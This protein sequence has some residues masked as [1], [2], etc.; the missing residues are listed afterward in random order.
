[1]KKRLLVPSTTVRKVARASASRMSSLDVIKC[2]AAFGVVAIHVGPDVLSFIVRASV[3]MFFLI[4]GYYYPKLVESG[5]FWPHVRKLVAMVLLSSLFYGIFFFAAKWHGGDLDEWLHETFR[6]RH[7][8]YCLVNDCDLFAFHLWFFYALIYDLVLLRLADK[9]GFTRWLEVLAPVLLFV[10][11][12]TNFFIV[13]CGW[14]RNFLFFGLPF[15]MFGRC[16]AEGKDKRLSLF[17][18]ARLFPYIAIGSLL[19]ALAEVIVLK[20]LHDR[21][22]RETYVFSVPFVLSVFY[23][24]LRNGDYGRG[25]IAAI[26]GR[27]YSAYIYILHVFVMYVVGKF[28]S[29][30]G[31]V[32]FALNKTAV[33]SFSL[34]VPVLFVWFKDKI[35][36]LY[37]RNGE[38]RRD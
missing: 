26:I 21:W 34:I 20:N 9:Y 8:A 11:L 36:S 33:Y 29:G 3:P 23:W 5:R 10:F 16:I 1:M 35:S 19:L 14:K 28:I 37:G 4:S 2:F 25:S 30:E 27:R 15:I 31:I 13:S 6:W 22:Q 32:M 7:F 24:A 38:L 12:A 17:G 18:N